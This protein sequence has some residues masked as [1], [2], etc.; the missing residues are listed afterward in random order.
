M[1]VS[2][3]GSDT[4]TSDAY[5]LAFGDTTTSPH[6]KIMGHYHDTFRRTDGVWQLARRQITVG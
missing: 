4:A 2:V 3:D 5:F 6:V 1:A